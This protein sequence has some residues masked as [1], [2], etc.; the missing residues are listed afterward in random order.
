MGEEKRMKFAEALEKV[1]EMCPGYY[2][3]R[4]EATVFADGV[5]VS[6]CSIYTPT[7]GHTQIVKEDWE[8]AIR[9]LQGKMDGVVPNPL[10]AAPE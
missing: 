3:L 8:G 4:Y 10:D 2:S 1:R 7:Y 5:I 6:T 9:D